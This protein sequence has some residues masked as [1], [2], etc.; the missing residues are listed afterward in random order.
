[1]PLGVEGVDGPSG[2]LI[3]ERTGAAFREQDE[4]RRAY[5]D[6]LIWGE[7]TC[8]FC[9]REVADRRVAAS[10]GVC[11]RRGCKRRAREEAVPAAR[12]YTLRRAR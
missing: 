1:M 2:A 10:P 7:S 4:A 11:A 3:G 6:R 9:G 8:R 12:A 5:L